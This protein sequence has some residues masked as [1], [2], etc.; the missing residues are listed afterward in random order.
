MDND[1]L[2]GRSAGKTD[3]VSSAAGFTDSQRLEFYVHHI[4]N[5]DDRLFQNATDDEGNLREPIWFWEYDAGDNEFQTFREALDAYMIEQ[6]E[7]AAPS[8]PITTAPSVQPKE[9]ESSCP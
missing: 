2:D 7:S 6:A 8:E 5:D 3:A 1:S 4:A 9:K